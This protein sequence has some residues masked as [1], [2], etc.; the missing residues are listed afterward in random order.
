MTI[1]WNATIEGTT[2]RKRQSIS[3]G[4]H[5]HT[6]DVNGLLVAKGTAGPEK[7]KLQF[8]KFP[9]SQD[10][11]SLFSYAD[12][13]SDPE[14]FLINTTDFMLWVESTSLQAG[15][16]RPP[17]PPNAG[18]DEDDDDFFTRGICV[19][20]AERSRRLISVTP[21]VWL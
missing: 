21:I 14:L 20:H 19:V 15:L 9:S 18:N 5:A 7:G 8:L 2:T 17:S 6:A 16:E 1:T 4:A 10:A 12:D 11:A 13:G 3:Q